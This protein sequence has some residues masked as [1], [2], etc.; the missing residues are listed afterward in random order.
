MALLLRHRRAAETLTDQ[1]RIR[2]LLVGGVVGVAAGSAVVFGYWRNPG[3]DIFATGTLTVLSLVF[4]AMPASF[5]YAILR[6]R[7]FDVSL[8]VRQGLRYALARRFV[9]ALIPILGAVLLVDVVSAPHAAARRD[10]EVALVVVYAGGSGAA[11]GPR[12]SRALA[13]GCGP[14]LLPGALR[15]AAAVEEHRGADQPRFEL[16]RHCAVRDAAD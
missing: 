10:A 2:V 5:V 8:I 14:P 3:P 11:R 7:L 9:D 16:R 15:C 13:E 1:R 12:P 6:H 4:L